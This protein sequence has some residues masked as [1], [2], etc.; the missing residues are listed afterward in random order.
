[1]G[2]LRGALLAAAMAVGLAWGGVAEAAL[3][4]MPLDGYPAFEVK[5][6]DGWPVDRRAGELSVFAP[7]SSAGGLILTITHDETLKDASL[8]AVARGL[9]PE[10]VPDFTRSEPMSLSRV[11]GQA[12]F[13]EWANAKG[14]QLSC[15]IVVVKVN[16]TTAAIQIRM[17]R[18]GN[19]PVQDEAL[20]TLFAS[21]HLIPR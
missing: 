1:M 18:A 5:A 21:A 11:K 2:D 13:A 16:P 9:L 4:R 6:P 10:G 7:D 20:D 19:D 8:E 17:R 15:V 3:L 12:F 14:A